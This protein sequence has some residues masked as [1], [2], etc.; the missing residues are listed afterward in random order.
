MNDEAVKKFA[1][2]FYI[3]L[4]SQKSREGVQWWQWIVPIRN[5]KHRQNQLLSAQG[6]NRNIC[7]SPISKCY[8]IDSCDSFFA[9][10]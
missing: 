5:A 8:G 9:V 7:I 4:Q 6:V 3:W 1:A 2:S 10:I